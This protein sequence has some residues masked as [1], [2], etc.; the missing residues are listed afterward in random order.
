MAELADARGLGPRGREAVRVRVSLPVFFINYHL[1]SQVFL[2][3]YRDSN[4]QEQDM[5]RWVVTEVFQDNDAE[6]KIIKLNGEQEKTFK[7]LIEIRAA[8]DLEHDA[9]IEPGLAFDVDSEA[10]DRIN[11]TSREGIEKIELQRKMQDLPDE[12]R[13]RLNK[14]LRYCRDAHDIKDVFESKAFEDLIRDFP[15]FEDYRTI[16]LEELEEDLKIPRKTYTDEIHRIKSDLAAMGTNE[17][18]QMH[19]HFKHAFEHPHIKHLKQ[20]FPSI[21]LFEKMLLEEIIPN[22]LKK[23]EEAK[24]ADSSKSSESTSEDSSGDSDSTDT[25]DTSSDVTTEPEVELAG[26][27]SAITTP[28]DPA[29]SEEDEEITIKQGNAEIKIKKSQLTSDLETVG[30]LDFLDD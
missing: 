20:G 29:E 17:R 12:A 6:V 8:A 7:T 23:K 24:V 18:L 28:S 13:H 2:V 27:L 1:I 30:D 22:P 21:E 5:E 26:G 19:Q 25:A 10:L 9:K 11:N 4:K 16:Q 3:R 15:V 14:L